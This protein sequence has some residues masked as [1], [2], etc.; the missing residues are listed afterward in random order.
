[1]SREQRQLNIPIHLLDHPLPITVV[2]LLDSIVIDGIV[3]DIVCH[4][5][6]PDNPVLLIPLL[7]A[8]NKVFPYTYAE[9]SFDIALEHTLFPFRYIDEVLLQNKMVPLLNRKIQRYR[10]LLDSLLGR[11]VRNSDHGLNELANIIG[12]SHIHTFISRPSSEFMI[13]IVM[14]IRL[15]LYY[16]IRSHRVNHLYADKY[17]H[18]YRHFIQ[19][20]RQ[21]SQ[22]TKYNYICQL[23]TIL[24]F[25]LHTVF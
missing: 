3:L 14:E 5:E 6:R 21:N 13:Q 9:R 1:M 24:Y 17:T 12:S 11:S 8:S 20:Q 15:Q 25:L 2:E 16:H 10:M 18:K 7:I 23:H 19:N 4:Q 22:N